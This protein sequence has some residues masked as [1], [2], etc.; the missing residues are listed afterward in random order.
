MD[1]NKIEEMR[2]IADK[3]PVLHPLMSM[4]DLVSHVGHCIS[5]PYPSFLATN[6]EGTFERRLPRFC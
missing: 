3:V 5:E 1:A 6:V 4:S 2:S